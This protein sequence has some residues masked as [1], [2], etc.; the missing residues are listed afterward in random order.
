MF[1]YHF[2]NAR[3]QLRR[4]GWYVFSELWQQWQQVTEGDV[5]DILRAAGI[6]YRRSKIAA[7]KRSVRQGLKDPDFGKRANRQ[8]G[9]IA[10]APVF[11]PVCH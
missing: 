10:P 6:K 4:D 2:P 9:I 1:H 5:D 3:L 7:A 8:A 11:A